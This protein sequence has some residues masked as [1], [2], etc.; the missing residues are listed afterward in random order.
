M[1]ANTLNLTLIYS[2]MKNE[3]LYI[4]ILCY[5]RKDGVVYSEMKEKFRHK[6]VEIDSSFDSFIEEALIEG[7]IYIINEN[8]ID[9]RE[10]AILIITHE[11]K[12]ML[13]NST[14]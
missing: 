9:D 5:N 13:K 11:G 7:L 10:D 6:F 3:I 8:K 12:K 2:K 1:T 4:L 14:G